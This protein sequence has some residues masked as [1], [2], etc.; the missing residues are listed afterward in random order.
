MTKIKICGRYRREDIG[1]VNEARPDYAGFVI[2]FPKSH[3]SLTPERAYELRLRLLHGIVPVGVFVDEDIDTVADLYFSGVIKVAQLHGGEDEAYMERLRR[4]A[5]G[6]T[7]WKAYSVK[8]EAD[9]A[10]A[11]AS[12]ANLVLLDNGQG[13]GRSF[14][15]SILAAFRRPFILAGGLTPESIP[16]AVGALHP[17]GVDLSS[18]VETNRVKD[19]DKI[20]AAVGAVRKE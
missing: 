9:L 19:R 1:F 16:L 2:D 10:A 12:P 17:W 4:A 8:R 13:T 14:D 15:W 18:G 5:P 3:R 6:L 20:M 11:E 7:V